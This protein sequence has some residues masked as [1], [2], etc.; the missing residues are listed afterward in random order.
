MCRMIAVMSKN[1]TGYKY[2]I[3]ERER[4][5]AFHSLKEQSKRAYDAPHKDGFGIYVASFGTETEKAN[6]LNV[7]TKPAYELLFKK[8]TPIT[9]TP[10]L[11]S[12]L[13][14]IKGNLLISHIRLASSGKGEIDNIHAHPYA[15]KEFIEAAGIKDVT[16]W[17]NNKSPYSA[18]VLAHN[19]TIYDL[20][21]EHM[22]DSQA[23]LNLIAENFKNGIDFDEFK[24]FIGDFVQKHDFTAI[25][26]LLKDPDN[27]LYALRLAKAKKIGEYPEKQPRLAYYSM[28]YLKDDSEGRV[29]VA[30][31]PIDSD[32]RWKCVDN[33]TLLKISKDLNVKIAEIS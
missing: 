29:I 14:N 22:T 17:K 1:K 11:S 15:D 8:G 3:E 16:D 9:E 26:F 30:S 19:G 18:Y 5:G 7:S 4:G 27:D 28:Y 2:I 21:D 25:N 23:L 10:E 13:D 31:E 6:G 24:I 33:Y 12:R 20:G 32:K